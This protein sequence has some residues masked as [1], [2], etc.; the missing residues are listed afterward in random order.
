[1]FTIPNNNETQ[2]YKW[3]KLFF[4]WFRINVYIYVRKII[5]WT[6]QLCRSFLF[7]VLVKWNR[8]L[9]KLNEIVHNVNH[10]PIIDSDNHTIA[11]KNISLHLS[12][13]I[14][15][16][17]FSS[18]SW[19]FCYYFHFISNLIQGFHLKCDENNL[20]E[21]FILSHFAST[22]TLKEQYRRCMYLINT[23]V[24]IK[25]QIKRHE[26]HITMATHRTSLLYY[27]IHLEVKKYYRRKK[28]VFKQ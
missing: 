13:H 12:F 5:I 11:Y 3:W 10:L 9:V 6:R 7:Y 25:I 16:R 1:M 15:I 20:H 4:L 27:I 28:I 17:S 8:I 18:I 26:N 21:F 23:I 14:R 24:H 19:M 22:H 2:N